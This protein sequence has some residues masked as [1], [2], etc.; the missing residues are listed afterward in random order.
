MSALEEVFTDAEYDVRGN[1]VIIVQ[2]NSKTVI[3]LKDISV[4]IYPYEKSK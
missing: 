2:G 4:I 1:F 3:P